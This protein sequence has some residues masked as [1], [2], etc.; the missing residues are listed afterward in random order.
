MP[1]TLIK[2]RLRTKKQNPKKKQELNSTKS[3]LPPNS[4]SFNQ[5]TI[6]KIKFFSI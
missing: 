2:S 5:K 6:I 3:S 4:Q 1:K